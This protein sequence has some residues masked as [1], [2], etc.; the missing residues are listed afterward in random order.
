MPDI[1]HHHGVAAEPARCPFCSSLLGPKRACPE[2]DRRGGYGWSL[3][4]VPFLIVAALLV[5]A[6][7]VV[8]LAGFLRT[9]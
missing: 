8:L 4:F 9:A 1:G 5:V 6:L 3:L 7:M 2:C